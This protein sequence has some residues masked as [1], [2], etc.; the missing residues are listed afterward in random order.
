MTVGDPASLSMVST[1]VVVAGC[2]RDRTRAVL[3]GRRTGGVLTALVSH[4]SLPDA[5][6]HVRV[7]SCGTD[8]ANHSIVKREYPTFR[9]GLAVNARVCVDVDTR[10]SLTAPPA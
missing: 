10:L 7:L 2:S 5:F 6:V 3:P 9:P 8:G 1:F 4:T